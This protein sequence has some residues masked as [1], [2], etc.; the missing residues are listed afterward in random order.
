MPGRL[1][2][3][4]LVALPVLDLY[5]LGF[6]IDALGLGPTLLL[7]F[8]SGALAVSVARGAGAMLLADLAQPSDGSPAARLAEGLLTLGAAGLLL[9]PGIV[10]DAVALVV[11]V[12]PIRRWLA[13]RI[14]GRI[15]LQAMPGGLGRG[16]GPEPRAPGEPRVRVGEIPRSSGRKDRP[17]PFTTPFD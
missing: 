5:T 12:P 14:A 15:E 11:L 7:V 13:P 3:L 8:G 17:N 16:G 2:L 6:V 1:L 4:L 10:S 9:F